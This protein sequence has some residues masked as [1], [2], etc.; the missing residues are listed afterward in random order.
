M[1]ISVDVQEDATGGTPAGSP[2]EDAVPV[3]LRHRWENAL[4]RYVAA[5]EEI[6]GHDQDAGMEFVGAAGAVAGASGLVAR[7]WRDILAS[8]LLPSWVAAA[9]DTAAGAFEAQ[10]HQF[11]ERALRAERALECGCGAHP[12]PAG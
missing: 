2:F 9:V 6:E 1:A 8:A 12:W 10:C 7:T 11:L 3:E 5:L 4:R